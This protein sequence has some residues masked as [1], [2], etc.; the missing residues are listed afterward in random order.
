MTR[1]VTLHGRVRFNTPL[2][3][4][5]RKSAFT[6]LLLIIGTITCCAAEGWPQQPVSVSIALGYKN[7]AVYGPFTVDQVVANEA[8][9][10]RQL[11]SPYQD[12]L[13]NRPFKDWH[14]LVAQYK[15]GDTIYYID[16]TKD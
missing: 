14:E 11:D 16:C 15:S 8:A 6:S 10:G 4:M 7:C 1:A 13:G 2:L 9:R 12:W 3:S 5:Y